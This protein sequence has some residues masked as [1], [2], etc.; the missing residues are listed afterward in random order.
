MG[1]TTETRINRKRRCPVAAPSLKTW[2]FNSGSKGLGGWRL[3]WVAHVAIATREHRSPRH[4]WT[5]PTHL[6]LPPPCVAI[7]PPVSSAMFPV[8][9]TAPLNLKNPGDRWWGRAHAKWVLVFALIPF[10]RNRESNRRRDGLAAEVKRHGT[11]VGMRKI[12]GRSECHLL[13]FPEVVNSAAISILA[14]VVVEL[15]PLVE[16]GG[17]WRKVSSAIARGGTRRMGSNRAS[18]ESPT[19]SSASRILPYDLATSTFGLVVSPSAASARFHPLD[20]H[21]GGT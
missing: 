12:A 1:T 9:R 17:A 2:F 7:P 19:K 13:E 20:C 16:T 3:L 8:A 11:E 18:K 14:Q 10:R 5:L 4:R 6:V 15:G 21:A